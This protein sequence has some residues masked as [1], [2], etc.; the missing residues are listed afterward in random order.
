MD[1]CHNM[2]RMQLAEFLRLD[3]LRSR[4]RGLTSFGA[5]G[6]RVEVA[7]TKKNGKSNPAEKST[8]GGWIM[9]I[10]LK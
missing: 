5:L 7:K 8:E 3:T 6:W 4:K 2:Q 1:A 10:Q 9:I